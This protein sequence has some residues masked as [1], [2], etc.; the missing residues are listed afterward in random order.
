MGLRYIV[1]QQL[2]SSEGGGVVPAVEIME[3]NG[4]IR[5]LIRDGKVHQIDS[6]IFNSGREGMQAMDAAILELVKKGKIDESEAMNHC[7]N[8]D[9]MARSLGIRQ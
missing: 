2:I 7:M 4:A 6:T 3:A 5:T 1:S 9:T 8:R